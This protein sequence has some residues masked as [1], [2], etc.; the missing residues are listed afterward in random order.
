VNL[1]R[2][3][4]TKQLRHLKSDDLEQCCSPSLSVVNPRPHVTMRPRSTFV[5]IYYYSRANINS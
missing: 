4:W 1:L 5:V 2:S 3:L